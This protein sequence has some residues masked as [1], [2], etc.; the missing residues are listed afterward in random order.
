MMQ[1]SLT[2]SLQPIRDRF[3]AILADR[4]SEILTSLEVAMQTP[5]FAT[6]ELERIGGVM[7]KIAGTAGTLGF[8]A[9]GESAQKIEFSILTSSRANGTYPAEL[10]T[11]IV[12]WLELSSGLTRDAD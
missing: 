4:Q 10:W 8:E 2:D 7:H 3:I 9:L 11:D 5:E 6:V 12:D 1:N